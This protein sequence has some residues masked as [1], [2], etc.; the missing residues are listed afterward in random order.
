[1][2][3]GPRHHSLAP[4]EDEIMNVRKPEPN[5]TSLLGPSPRNRTGTLC[6]GRGGIGPDAPDP[7]GG[8]ETEG[9]G[10]ERGEERREEERGERRGERREEEEERRREER[11]EGGGER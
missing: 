8:G 5:S 9:E 4:R 10:I 1:M 2:F 6:P 11:G 7:G 3:P